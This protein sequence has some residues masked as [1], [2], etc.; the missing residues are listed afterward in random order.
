M[1][2]AV[3]G[4]VL[5]VRFGLGIDTLDEYGA[6]MHGAI[7]FLAC[8]AVAVVGA[9][10][11]AISAG[12]LSVRSRWLGAPAVLALAVGVWPSIERDW[13]NIWA[14]WGV[15]C[16]GI[17]AV[18]VAA[19]SV[20]TVSVPAV[21]D[22]TAD[23]GEVESRSRIVRV[24]DVLPPVWLLFAATFVT[25]IVA[26]SPRDLRVEW[27]SLPLGIGL[28][29]AGALAAAKT[30]YAD[31]STT[32]VVGTRGT[33]SDWPNGWSGSWA[34]FG[35]GLIVTISASML[36]TFTDPQTWR[37][38]L[39]IVIAL[40]AIIVGAARR[41]AAPF[42]LGIIVLPVENVIAFAVQIGRGIESMPWWIT[43]A[44]V[45]AVLLTIAVTYERRAGE[46]ETLVARLRDLR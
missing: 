17:V 46:A 44:I 10:V 18:V 24:A 6:S 39:V 23:R 27:F 14:M 38:I 5:G 25:A 40:I 35:P 15:M 26:W 3:A 43:L 8:L 2:A 12:R 9:L 37:A 22:A 29:A 30:R 4:P 13:F 36:A 19:M 31:G 45:G 32:A 34:H 16:L 11:L 33:L 1:L 21:P 42:L 7:L 20:V 41:L 28:L